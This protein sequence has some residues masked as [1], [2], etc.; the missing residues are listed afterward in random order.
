MGGF[1][2]CCLYFFVFLPRPQPYNKAPYLIMSFASKA[3][4]K[5]YLSP[6]LIGIITS[7]Q[8]YVNPLPVAT[9]RCGYDTGKHNDVKQYWWMGVQID[10][11]LSSPHILNNSPVIPTKT[12]PIRPIPAFLLHELTSHCLEW[13]QCI[14]GWRFCLG[15]SETCYNTNSRLDVYW[16]LKINYKWV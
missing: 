3:N 11:G 9:G 8:R 7:V 1:V 12:C 13:L 5:S 2:S 4:K 6:E 10:R 15:G 16:L 14:A